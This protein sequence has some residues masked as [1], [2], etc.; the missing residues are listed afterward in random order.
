MGGT[1]SYDPNNIF[2]K[3]IRCEVPCKKV[4]E[5]D[6]AIAFH[7]LHPSA[8]VH[9]LVIPKGEY[10]SFDDFT[11]KATPT[12]MS[13]FYKSVQKV[14]S[15][16]DLVETGY[17]LVAN[18]GPDASQAVPHFHI[19]LLGKRKLGPIVAGDTYHS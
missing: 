5:N 16:L 17:R 3:I 10:K 15:G 11:Q 14:A 1:M 8:P 2:A 19:H 9:V 4:Y 12:E 7:D 6:Y 18:H 13:E